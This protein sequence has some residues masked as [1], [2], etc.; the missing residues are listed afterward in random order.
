MQVCPVASG[1]GNKNGVGSGGVGA[2][3]GDEGA[4]QATGVKKAPSSKKMAKGT[5]AAEYEGEIAALHQLTQAFGSSAAAM[6]DVEL[7]SLARARQDDS[8]GRLFVAVRFFVDDTIV[9]RYLGSKRATVAKMNQASSAAEYIVRT[10][11][12]RDGQT[13]A[14]ITVRGEPEGVGEV[15]LGDRPVDDFA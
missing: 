3:P 11:Q 9:G 2:V 10:R 13:G 1:D 12:K 7:D 6:G 15:R 4:E 5:F 8:A 14:W